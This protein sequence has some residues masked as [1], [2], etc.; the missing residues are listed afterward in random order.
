ME[1]DMNK[2]LNVF[3]TR[4]ELDSYKSIA[5]KRVDELMEENKILKER[6][7]IIENKLN[8]RK[9]NKQTRKTGNE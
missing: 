6:I 3:P 4:P 9:E 1:V 5:T 2:L 7:E 8:E